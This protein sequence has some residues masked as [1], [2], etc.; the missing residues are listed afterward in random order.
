MSTKA[1]I[2]F[3]SLALEEARQAADRD[4]VPVGAILVNSDTGA[5]LA[6]AGNEVEARA[7][8][9]AH[10]EILVIRAAAARARPSRALGRAP[11]HRASAPAAER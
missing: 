11:P 6:R 3:M 5:V 2:S 8:P 9:T 7:D 1:A 4:E 10:A